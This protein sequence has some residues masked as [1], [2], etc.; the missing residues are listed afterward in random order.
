MRIGYRHYTRL[1]ADPLRS[2]GGSIKEVLPKLKPIEG[3]NQKGLF[4]YGGRAK[5]GVVSTVARLFKALPAE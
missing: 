4:T 3:L 5:P 2:R 1:L